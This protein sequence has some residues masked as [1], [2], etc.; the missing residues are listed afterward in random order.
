M[1]KLTTLQWSKTLFSSL[2]IIELYLILSPTRASDHAISSIVRILSRPQFAQVEVIHRLW[3]S[4]SVALNQLASVWSHQG[5]SDE[6][7]WQHLGRM[8]HELEAESQSFCFYW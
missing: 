2:L 3:A 8:T 4:L 6:V 7:A 5:V 1:H